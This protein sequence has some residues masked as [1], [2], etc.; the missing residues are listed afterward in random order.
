[1]VAV[2]I[3]VV[4]AVFIAAFYQSQSENSIGTQYLNECSEAWP[5]QSPGQN[6][7]QLETLAAMTANP[8]TSAKICVE[9]NSG[10]SSSVISPLNGSIYFANN[11]SNVP[12]SILQVSSQ[13]A[14]LK[15]PAMRGN[16][17][18][19]VAYA[20]FT[21]NVSSSARGFYMLS[22]EGICPE[23]Q[24]AVG[25]SQINY[26]DFAFGW[27]HRYQCTSV[28]FFGSYFSVSNI[29]VAYSYVPLGAD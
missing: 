15:A 11:M 16:S 3:L 2:A 9:Y 28:D 18:S 20:V 12:A 6:T 10:S 8:G 26:S 7:T 24:L 14:T 4:A 22:L 17:P 29:G 5:P 23:M 27:Q 25:Y 13:P 1:V 21:L 19:P